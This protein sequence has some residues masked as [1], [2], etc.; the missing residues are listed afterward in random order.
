[1]NVYFKIM[2]LFNMVNIPLFIDPSKI[3]LWSTEIL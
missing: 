3:N 2:K 1:M